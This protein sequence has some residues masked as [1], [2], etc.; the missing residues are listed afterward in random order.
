MLQFKVEQVAIC[1]K[2]PAAAIELL[3]AMGAS[4]WARDHVVAS[5]TVFGSQGQTNE[6]DLAFNYQLGNA[7][8]P[9]EFEVL[10]YTD[11]DNWMNRYDRENTASHLGM[12]CSADELLQWREFFSERNIRVA[13]EVNTES[14]SNPVIAG[15]RFYNYVIFATKDILGIDVKFIVRRNVEA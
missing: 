5:G 2:D 1:P 3:T 7:E 4:D 13:Q 12:H 8:T 9:L 15:K 11:G 10:H 14:H 6:A